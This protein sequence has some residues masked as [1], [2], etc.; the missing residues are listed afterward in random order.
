MA[1]DRVQAFVQL[2]WGWDPGCAWWEVGSLCPPSPAGDRILVPPGGGQSPHACQLKPGTR[3][4]ACLVE[5]MVS[6]PTHTSQGQDPRLAG[7]GF[8]VST[9]QSRRWD[10]TPDWQRVH[11][12]TCPPEPGTGPRTAGGGG[13]PTLTHPIWRCDSRLA[14]QGENPWAH[15]SKLGTET[16][17]SLVGGGDP[18]PTCLGLDPNPAWQEA[19][20][21]RPP[22]QATE[23][24][25]GRLGECSVLPCACPSQRRD[26]G[27]PGGG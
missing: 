23:E 3:S 14:W 7:S 20:S 11:P 1:S 17:A 27:L 18:T 13:V 24:T 4:H 16:Q 25:P 10:P 26:M 15:P 8:P 12:C 6:T 19:A 21:P 5:G 9:R 22:A 2:S